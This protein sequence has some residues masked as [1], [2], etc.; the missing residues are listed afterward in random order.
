MTQFKPCRDRNACTE[1]GAVCKGCGRT[2][3]EIARIRAL[4][5]E[6]VGYVSL[7]HYDNPDEF[8]AYLTRKVLK[9]TKAPEKAPE[10]IG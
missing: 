1:D 4:V 5:N 9:K 2:H 10:P 8:M 7:M 6:L 3:V